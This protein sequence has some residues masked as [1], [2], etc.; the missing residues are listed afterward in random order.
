MA[1]WTTAL[2]W[3]A[4]G[5]AATAWAMHWHAGRASTPLPP[6]ATAPALPTVDHGAMQRALNGGALPAAAALAVAAPPPVAGRFQVK[7]VAVAGAKSVVLLSI[8][9]QPAKPVVMGAE[10]ADGWLL[11]AVTHQEVNL[12]R[13]NGGTERLRL[14]VPKAAR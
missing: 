14:E 5:F 12:R 9:G 8:D 1:K 10:A 2:A 3:L 11:H 7:G 6:L 4:L 13:G